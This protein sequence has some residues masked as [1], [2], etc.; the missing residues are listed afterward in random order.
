[1][2]TNQDGMGS[3]SGHYGIF[4]HTR[5]STNDAGPGT[6]GI[7]IK[8][9]ELVTTADDQRQDSG[10]FDGMVLRQFEQC[11]KADK[12]WEHMAEYYIEEY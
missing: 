2:H 12:M 5:K 7:T 3:H 11:N 6:L 4:L 8:M 1:M 10:I 9:S